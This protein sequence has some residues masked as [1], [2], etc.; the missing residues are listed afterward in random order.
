MKAE[1][2]WYELLLPGY[3]RFLPSFLLYL[4]SGIIK[5]KKENNLYL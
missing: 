5:E 2:R 1:W 4:E 3:S